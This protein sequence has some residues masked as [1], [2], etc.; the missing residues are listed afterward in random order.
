VDG[1][2]VDPALERCQLGNGRIDASH[3]EV[4]SR[5][6]GI[7]VLGPLRVE[8]SANGLSPRDR[9]VVS[10]LVMRAGDPVTQDALAD[11]LWGDEVPATW[12]KVVQGCIVR[13]RKVLGPAAIESGSWGYRLTLTEDE[14]D[15]RT[16][17]RLLERGREALAAQDPAR[18]SYLVQEALDLWRGPALGD[19]EDWGPGRVEAG[20]LE[21]LRMDAEE[22]WVEAEIAAGHPQTVLER[23]R[24]LVAQASFRERRWAL[25]ATALYQAGRQ[26]EA[27]GALKHA[28]AMLVGE[29][30]LDPGPELVRLEQLLLHQDPSLSPPV[31]RGTSVVCPYRGLLPY[32]TEDA[33]TFFGR[34]D[35][36]AACLRRLRD[37][38]VLTVVGPSGVGKSS[39]VRAG[40]VASLVRSGT[41]V[42]VTTPGAHP[43]DSL[44]ALKP[45]GR[46][47][48]VVDQAEEAVTLCHEPAERARYFEAL[49]VHVGAGGA[50][51]VSLRAD[52]LGDLAPYPEIAR[53]VEEGLYLLGPLGADGLRSAIEGPAHRAGLRLEP[54]L[55][56]L[57]VRDVEGE[58]AA[59]P[60]LSH[61]LRETWQRREGPTLTVAGYRATGGIRQAVAQSAEALYD[62]M[63]DAERA[64]LRG[65]LLRLVM[66]N[67]DGD[68][69]RT[70][71]PR[72]KVAADAAHS[73]L[74]E[75]LVVARLVAV[76]GDSLQIAH[77]ALVRVW[78]RLRG[79]LD[80]DVEG[81]RT[82]QHL[83][84]A[85][86]AWDR[87]GR[88]DSELYRGGRLT[89]ALEWRGGTGPTLVAVEAAFLDAGQ[90]RAEDDLHTAQARIARQRVENRRLRG[91]LASV[92]VLLVLAFVAGAVA[93]R[94]LDRARDARALA[95]ARRAGAEA[96]L[97]EDLTRG[98][99]LAVAALR[100][101]A[102]SQSWDDLGATLTR[103]G[104][105]IGQRDVGAS[106]GRVGASLRDL[107]V[108]G[109][110]SVI[111]TTTTG[112]GV[113]LFDATTLEP[114]GFAGHGPASDVVV[115]PDGRTAV[116]AVNQ[117][118]GGLPHIDEHPLRV[119]DLPGGE[120]AAR[121]LGGIPPN[122]SVDYTLCLSADGRRVAAI[123]FEWDPRAG[124]VTGFGHYLVWD[125]AHPE[126]PVLDLRMREYA[127]LA[128][129]PDGSR[130]YVYRAG[131]HVLRVFDVDSGRLLRTSTAILVDRSAAAIDASPDG[132]RIAVGSGPLIQQYDAVTLRPLGSPM[133]G[134]HGPVEQV[135]YSHDGSLL[136][137]SSADRSAVLWDSRTGARLHRFVAGRDGQES[138]EF[139]PDDR[140]LYTS[141]D[142]GVIRAWRVSGGSRLLALGEATEALATAGADLVAAA[143]DGHTVARVEGGA[144][145][146]VDADTGARRRAGRLRA[147]DLTMRWS[148]DA[149]WLLT[150]GRDGVL[151]IWDPRSG[152]LLATKDL[153]ET[154]GERVQ[155][156][157][158]GSRVYVAGGDGYLRTLVRAT[159]ETEEVVYAGDAVRAVT[160]HPRDGSVF[161][162]Q[163]DGSFLRMHPETGY[164]FQKGPPG[165]LSTEDQ[166]GI[167]SPDGHT[168]TTI[169][170]DDHVRLLDLDTL[171]YL[172]SDPGS[173]FSAGL[174]YA[175]DGSQ[176]ASVQAERIRLWD[177]RTGEYR[178]S[179]RLPD[180]AADF[181]MAYLP[182]SSGLLLAATDGRTWTV[183]THTSTWVAHAC[184]IAGRN[185]TRA[186]WVQSFPTRDYRVTCPEWPAGT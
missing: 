89:R 22:V 165:L 53:V 51:V 167:V 178:A 150:N 19:L 40:V 58:P 92:A 87:M 170:G 155:F 76:D 101:D 149:R 118:T 17:E 32:A 48:L 166:A 81:Q 10:A 68:P 110:G 156:S 128:L 181:S 102:S 136:A 158:D 112:E 33:D 71:L 41:P 12:T 63:D 36:V 77:E 82:L 96:P 99:L 54:G 183:D 97:Q 127:K 163:V 38:R 184:S 9:V 88:P 125:L 114:A 157:A 43:V 105:Q 91:A 171:D 185:L 120:P 104:A 139:A 116:W 122:T 100:E 93:L 111:A 73:G 31:V 39:L 67:D 62:A 168:M 147:A 123:L 159:L 182:D 70:R 7:A 132:T 140:T 61:A 60:L 15:H 98:L 16:F 175:P 108:A 29:L 107:A 52:H 18:S 121:Q 113:P 64:R 13:L 21:G 148:A 146:F 37:A 80:D 115:T 137:S 42:L 28:R 152:T 94:S 47:T 174:A 6:M 35:D 169:S 151:R 72:A 133:L 90:A 23:A 85:A 46:Q 74:V 56:D 124:D 172:G 50:L 59:L 27:L 119:A 103:A 153:G 106:V 95:D 135:R 173:G 3:A 34:H 134:H 177:G 45:R 145:W 8:G 138:V 65:L 186:E 24:V 26:S 2:G 154:P 14:L 109:D 143:P 84:A 69:V 86:D 164:V 179:L 161:V 57:L 162:M 131:P 117:W 11:A 20:R 129:S 176:F 180:A 49:A 141:G 160:V 4:D 30:G 25:L 1:S 44:S 66:P 83:S 142:D 144:L 126:V 75:Q 78:P 55:V 79:W 130:L 5:S